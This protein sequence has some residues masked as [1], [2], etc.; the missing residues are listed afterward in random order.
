MERPGGCPDCKEEFIEAAGSALTTALGMTVRVK[1]PFVS[2]PRK[3]VVWAA[4]EIGILN[5][6]ARTITCFRGIRAGCG[7]CPACEARATAFR[8]AGIKDPSQK[9]SR[10]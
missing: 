2:V 1:A 3:E 6:I 10:R 7:K 4:E 9:K 8:E 5:L